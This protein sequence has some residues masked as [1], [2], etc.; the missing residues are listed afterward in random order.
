MR[1]SVCLLMKE[2]ARTVRGRGS[3]GSRSDHGVYDVYLNNCLPQSRIC[4]IIEVGV[5]CAGG[6]I[7]FHVIV[8][9]YLTAAS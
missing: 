5:G 3:I 2:S 4:N 8:R 6:V 7:A 1:E 9:M